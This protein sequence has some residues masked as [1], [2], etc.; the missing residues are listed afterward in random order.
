M[1]SLPDKPTV[2]VDC[3]DTLVMWNPTQ[4]QLEKD[5]IDFE[6]PGSFTI[7]DGEMLETP[8][9]MERL[10]PHKKHIEQIK[11]H[12]MRGHLVVVWSAGGAS[13]AASVAKTLGL[14][15]YVDLTISKPNWVYDDLPSG[16][17]MPKAKWLKD[18][19]SVKTIKEQ[20]AEDEE[21]GPKVLGSQTG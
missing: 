18:D 4:E 10:V 2:Y 6:C 8:A 17:F 20:N 9:W 14:E 19:D 16:E 5:G 11:K 1:I 7:I 13:W 12:K 21:I 15:N 3:D